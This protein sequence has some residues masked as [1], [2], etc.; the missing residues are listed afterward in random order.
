[1]L[2][3]SISR[4]FNEFKAKDE[5]MRDSERLGYFHIITSSENAVVVCLLLYKTTCYAKCRIEYLAE[6]RF[7]DVR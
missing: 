1:M 3:C 6:E 5:F 2:T 4:K 7:L